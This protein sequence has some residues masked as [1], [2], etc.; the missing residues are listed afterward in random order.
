M[1]T[2]TVVK[3]GPSAATNTRAIKMIGNPS[4]ISTRRMMT[5]SVLPPK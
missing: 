5:A 2:M 4:E 1:T 3:L